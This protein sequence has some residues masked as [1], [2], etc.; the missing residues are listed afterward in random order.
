MAWRARCGRLLLFARGRIAIQGYQ[1]VRALLF[2]LGQGGARG[3]RRTVPPL[4]VFQGRDRP[5]R[6]QAKGGP[7]PGAILFEIR[8]S[9][10]GTAGKP[11]AG[12]EKALPPNRLSQCRRLADW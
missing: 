1:D 9:E 2:D 11:S 12:K 8:V 6:T 7:G 3:R 5:H 10:I 4:E